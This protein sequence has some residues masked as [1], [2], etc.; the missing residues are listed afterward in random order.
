MSLLVVEADKAHPFIHSMDIRFDGAWSC[1][2]DP[3]KE[4]VTPLSCHSLGL[5]LERTHSGARRDPLVSERNPVPLPDLEVDEG[6]VGQPRL[7][8]RRA[9]LEHHSHRDR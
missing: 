7:H 3:L 5:R 2:L 8:S 9:L 1:E 6:E 4:L